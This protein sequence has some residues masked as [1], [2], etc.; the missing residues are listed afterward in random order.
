MSSLV[1]QGRPTRKNESASPSPTEHK[2]P[3]ELT[4]CLG[5]KDLKRPMCHVLEWRW[6]KKDKPC[7][8]SKSACSHGRLAPRQNIRFCGWVYHIESLIWG[9]GKEPAR[10]AAV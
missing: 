4:A 1:A 5:P 6:R 7:L 10:R 2:K 3:K 8:I 9:T